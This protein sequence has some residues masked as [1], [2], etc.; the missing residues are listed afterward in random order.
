MQQRLS[1]AVNYSGVWTTSAA[2]ALCDGLMPDEFTELASVLQKV[3]YGQY[4]NDPD[5][6]TVERWPD[7]QPSSLQNR[8]R[9]RLLL[10]QPWCNGNQTVRSK[11]TLAP[12]ALNAEVA[13]TI[14]ASMVWTESYG[15]ARNLLD[16]A[17]TN[18]QLASALR[19]TRE[20]LARYVA[21]GGAVPA[22][23][24][25]ALLEALI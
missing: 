18:P 1:F 22:W 23:F 16:S 3:A 8:R 5:M 2:Y 20:A 21:G 15:G 19:S 14:M 4:I 11:R 13:L 17:A 10:A 12:P 9:Y 24:P 6:P 25:P 7:G